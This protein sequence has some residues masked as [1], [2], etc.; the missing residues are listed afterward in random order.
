[1]RVVKICIVVDKSFAGISFLETDDLLFI[2]VSTKK[3]DAPFTICRIDLTKKH[4]LDKV[5]VFDVCLRNPREVFVY[6]IQSLLT[7]VCIK[8]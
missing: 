3:V 4:W 7:T 2:V 6:H 5:H 1:M 8:L